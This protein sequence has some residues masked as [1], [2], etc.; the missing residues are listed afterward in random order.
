MSVLS[1]SQYVS[2]NGRIFS[3]QAFMLSGFSVIRI[4]LTIE[5]NITIRNCI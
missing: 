5:V 2:W 4:I 1:N 3:T